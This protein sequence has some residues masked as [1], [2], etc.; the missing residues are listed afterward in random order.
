MH[1]RLNRKSETAPRKAIPK[2]DVDSK[3]GEGSE[4][5]ALLPPA[6]L[7]GLSALI[8]LGR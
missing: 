5:A 3:V 7:F 8:G 4:K 6:G 1:P 2:G